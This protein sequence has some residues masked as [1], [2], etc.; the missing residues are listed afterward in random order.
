VRAPDRSAPLL[1]GADLEIAE[2]ETV[3]VTGANGAGKSTLAAVLLGFGQLSKGTVRIP[4]RPAITYLPERPAFL[5]ATIEANLRLARHDA[6]EA[7]MWNALEA[8]GA[9]GFVHRLGGLSYR[10]G[11]GGAPLSAGERQRLALARVFLRPA[12]LYVLDE[13]TAHLDRPAESAVVDRLGPLLAS[14]GALIITHRPALL[15][16]A[17]R[18]LVMEGGRLLTGPPALVG[19]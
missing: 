14:R 19:R 16:L 18:A 2:G 7:D 6:S 5:A 3:V 4:P 11:P 1:D 10:L 15:R 13:P 17:D 9:D 8:S 12:V